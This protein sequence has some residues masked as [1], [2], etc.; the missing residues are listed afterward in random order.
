MA[1]LRHFWLFSL[2]AFPW[3]PAS[4]KRKT[5]VWS[6]V[7]YSP[8]CFLFV[9]YILCFMF[10]SAYLDELPDKCYEPIDL[11]LGS[12]PYAFAEAGVASGTSSTGAAVFTFPRRLKTVLPT[13][14]ATDPPRTAKASAQSTVIGLLNANGAKS[15]GIGEA[16]PGALFMIWNAAAEIPANPPPKKLEQ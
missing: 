15:P 2:Y 5:A 7:Q 10:L 16:V 1:Q 4:K 9:F 6:E 12:L 11:S 3:I 14:P 13:N 8:C